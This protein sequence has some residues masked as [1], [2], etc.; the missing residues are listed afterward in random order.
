[1]FQMVD[2]VLPRNHLIAE[3]LTLHYFIPT[4]LVMLL[5]PLLGKHLFAILIHAYGRD[6]YAFLFAALPDAVVFV[7]DIMLVY[8]GRG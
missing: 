2:H 7:V 1:M 6:E 5:L 8:D 3:P 4:P